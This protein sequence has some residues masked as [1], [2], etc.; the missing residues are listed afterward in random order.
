ME[1][2]RSFPQD[3]RLL[4]GRREH[5]VT[6]KARSLADPGA[7]ERYQAAN[8]TFARL[9][10]GAR[11]AASGPYDELTGA[12]RAWVV[13]TY[14]TDVLAADDSARLAG[15]TDA[16]AHDA[17]D[18]GWTDV[19]EQG[20]LAVVREMMGAD[21]ASIAARQG[22][23]FDKTC[24]A[25][26]VLCLDLVRTMVRANRVRMERDRGHPLATPVAPQVMPAVENQPACVDRKNPESFCAIVVDE[27]ARPTFSGG[28][29]T[30]QSWRTALRYF[31]ETHGDLLPA[32]ITRRH[33]S[34]L[35]DQL[36]LAPVKRAVKSK[37][38]VWPLSKLVEAYAGKD[39]QR[40]SWKSRQTVLGALQAAWTKS[41]RSGRI[42]DDGGNPFS[43]PNLGKAPRKRTNDGISRDI[44]RAIFGLS[45][46]TSGARVSPRQGEAGYWMPL[47]L[48]T[49][50]ARP[51]ELAQALVED[52]RR[53]A[54]GHWWLTVTAEGEHPAKGQ[55]TLKSPSAERSVY[56]PPIL[57]SLGFGD[58]LRWLTEGGE[59]ALF[60][61]LRPKGERRELFAGF[62]IW[63]SRYLRDNGVELA[64]KRPSRE[65][66][67]TWTTIA[68]ECGM[69]RE[70]QDF[71][72]G[73]APSANDMNARYGSREPLRRE[74]FKLSFDG[75]GLEQ[76]R[77]WQAPSQ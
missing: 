68:R 15:Q 24:E 21:A 2:R 71:L 22:W 67:P 25:F 55:R 46:F 36:A 14:E 40:L 43:R 35:A 73:H 37:E 75:W 47:L 45:V 29:S 51:E 59:S 12:R 60:P 63:W 34:E 31:R 62:G 18:S 28:P 16:E 69:T 66:R 57:V 9:V 11:R 49:T 39:V 1:Y 8:E 61:A 7:M 52:V 5:I 3:L 6:L 27:M 19:L 77:R 74:A 58:Y 65:F 48:I 4:L 38:R 26:G 41:Q 10:S 53:D 72:M 76:V 42:E 30:K 50:G 33:A 56:L 70:A 23:V 32:Q 13:A 44:S 20:D 17:A 54:E 64:G